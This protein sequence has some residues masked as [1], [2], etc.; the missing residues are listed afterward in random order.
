MRAVVGFGRHRMLH[1]HQER[2]LDV[3]VVADAEGVDL[4]AGDRRADVRRQ[5]D[6]E[7]AGVEDVAAGPRPSPAR[8]AARPRW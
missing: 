5:L 8:A 2:P 1:H 6:V 3:D 7:R 4:L